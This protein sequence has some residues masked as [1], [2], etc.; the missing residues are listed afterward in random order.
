VSDKA[1]LVEIGSE[2][3]TLDEALVSARYFAD[4]LAEI[5]E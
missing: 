2:L 4:V 5:L 3:N 1:I